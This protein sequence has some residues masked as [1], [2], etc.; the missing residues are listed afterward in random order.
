MQYISVL[1]CVLSY[2]SVRLII[3]LTG[4]YLHWL[5]YAP[6]YLKGM[7]LVP[8]PA[9]EPKSYF[10]TNTHMGRFMTDKVLHEF[11]GKFACAVQ[12]KQEGKTMFDERIVKSTRLCRNLFRK[13]ELI[14]YC[15]QGLRAAVRQIVSHRVRR[16]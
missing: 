11:H 6:G 16:M 1:K 9:V 4:S 12:Y 2:I 14:N 7:Q 3:W 13:F 8:H 15:T 10:I 5:Q